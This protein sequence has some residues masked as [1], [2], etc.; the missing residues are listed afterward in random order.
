M[1]EQAYGIDLHLHTT[2]SDGTRTV[3]EVMQDAYNFGLRH[4]A[5]TDHNQFAITEPVCFQKMEVIP[6]AEFS[7]AYRTENGRLLEVHVVGLFFEG[8]PKQI[9]DIFKRI[10]L[11]RKQY[12]DAIIT[13]LN[14]LG[15]A[16]SYEELCDDFP[17]SNQIGRRHIAELLVKKQYA[18]SITD[19]F[20][21]LIGNRSPYWVDS[22]I[23]MR[24]MPL[25][26]CVRMICENGGFP[27]LAHP[28]H[29]H[30]SEDEILTL[31]RIFKKYTNN[32]PAGLEVFYSKYDENRRKQLA[33]IAKRFELFPSAASDRHAI[34]DRFERGEEKL[35]QNMKDACESRKIKE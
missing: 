24:Y 17:D 15:I 1:R 18:E 3:S 22:S 32:E 4:I 23:Y 26:V 10:P 30:C 19:A 27:I 14:H 34:K 8:V 33:A 6:G 13:R 11:Q 12:L 7:A 16:L 20:D 35:L 31:V 21:R 5:I 25:E 9:H 28:Y 29:Y 2:N